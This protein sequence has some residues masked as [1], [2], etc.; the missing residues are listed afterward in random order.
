MISNEMRG[1]FSARE[2]FCF[3]RSWT[4]ALLMFFPLDEDLFTL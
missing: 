1:I 3:S 4:S 2:G